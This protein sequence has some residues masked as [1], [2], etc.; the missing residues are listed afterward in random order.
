LTEAD[1]VSTPLPPL[2]P[3]TAPAAETTKKAEDQPQQKK[4]VAMVGTMVDKDDHVTVDRF[5]KL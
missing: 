5:K 4:D 2:S 1:I 3:P